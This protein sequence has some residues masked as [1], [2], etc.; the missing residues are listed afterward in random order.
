MISRGKSKKQPGQISLAK[1]TASRF[2]CMMKLVLSAQGI[3]KA[4][5]LFF[6]FL[7]LVIKFHVIAHF[8]VGNT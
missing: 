7:T 3:F 8:V 4:N 6:F 1:E 5:L 2:A